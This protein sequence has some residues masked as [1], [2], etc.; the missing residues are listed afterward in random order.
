MA[1]RT[2]QV[3]LIGDAKRFDAALTS[4]EKRMQQFGKA[5]AIAGA[6]AATGL[7]VI[8][9]KSIQAGD[10][11]DKAAKRTGLATDS[12]QK[13]GFAA[14][15]SGTSFEAVE[16]GVTRLSRNLLD[17]EHSAFSPG[18]RALNALGIE[19]KDLEG[20][21]TEEKFLRVGDALGKLADDSEQ[22]GRAQELFGRA[23]TQ[24]IPLFEEGRA[25]IERLGDELAATGNIMSEDMV[26]S[27]A[28][29]NDQLNVMQKV[30][31]GLAYQAGSVLVP[32][33]G[34]VLDAVTDI[35][36]ALGLTNFET[37]QTA[38]QLG[39]T[40][41]R[42]DRLRD[43]VELTTEQ[44]LRLQ[45]AYREG[46]L[47]GAEV[48]AAR[49]SI[50]NGLIAEK[51][52]A[53]DA[54][55][56]EEEH[57]QALKDSAPVLIR[58]A[59]LTLQ[60]YR[61]Q[62]L[63]A[64]A[65]E[66]AGRN[67]DAMAQIMDSR[68]SSI[69]AHA[70]ALR[71]AAGA[72]ADI[73]NA[74]NIA[75][76]GAA[77]LDP[78]SGDVAGAAANVRSQAF[79][80]AGIGTSGRSGL[81]SFAPRGGSASAARGGG[82]SSAGG[83][84]NGMARAFARRRTILAQMEYEAAREALEAAR[85]NVRLV[86]ENN[87]AAERLQTAREQEIKEWQQAADAAVRA[88]QA[89]QAADRRVREIA[90]AQERTALLAGASV[91]AQAQAAVDQH[92]IS[93]FRARGRGVQAGLSQRQLG[94]LGGFA[95]QDLNATDLQQAEFFS[96][97]GFGSRVD[98]Y[99]AQI[100]ESNQAQLDAQRAALEQAEADRRAQGEQVAAARA[101]NFDLLQQISTVRT[102][103][104]T[105]LLQ[106]QEQVRVN[107]L[108][109]AQSNEKQLALAEEE[110]RRRDAAFLGS[111]DQAGGGAGLS[112]LRAAQRRGYS[113]SN[114]LAAR[115]YV[116][117]NQGGGGTTVVQQFI[118]PPYTEDQ[119]AELSYMGLQELEARGSTQ[120]KVTAG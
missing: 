102:H 51:A 9:V 5:A 95:A 118:T 84:D 106:A 10:A 64:Q 26:R 15:Q 38:G 37:A 13:L 18:A 98:Q 39:I 71:M 35:T 17:A 99:L 85:E 28:Q 44:E 48:V 11:I 89:W 41:D 21:T 76:A 108:Q 34:E 74:A 78:L 14:E 81:P 115:D 69:L 12:I 31:S 82:A 101:A 77:F 6:A 25:G 61:E 120:M 24:L 29:V 43:S 109:I 27:A 70:N 32:A 100:A 92:Q 107:T 96:R 50:I 19:L 36:D 104:N 113:G 20:L 58:Q 62:D 93:L 57:L 105:L 45:Q 117:S 80:S 54:R 52:A 116:Q 86:K 55:R 46:R 7:A 119:A 94:R 4:S 103:E 73:H 88:A 30:A 91:L 56:A 33:L 111:L 47:T 83:G 49:E 65:S 16:K 42:Y 60:L 72:Y 79:I 22:A 90:T 87:K 114:L 40:S 66:T 75:S 59:Q 3:N 68:N 63:M 23:G 110:R 112:I 53:E 2:L 67:I 1:S 97:T 8:T